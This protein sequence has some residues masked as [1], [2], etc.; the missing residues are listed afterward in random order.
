M[1]SATKNEKVFIDPNTNSAKK[2]TESDIEKI[3]N[4][5]KNDTQIV[6]QQPIAI[7]NSMTI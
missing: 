1:Y 3:C 7:V 5:V 6:L 2:L 4:L